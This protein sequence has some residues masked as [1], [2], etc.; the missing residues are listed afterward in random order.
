MRIGLIIYGSL[1]TRTG[2]YI[3]DK[4]LVAHLRRLG[5]ETEVISLSG[6]HYGRHLFDNVIPSVYARIIHSSVDLLLQDGLCHPSLFI[7]NNKLKRTSTLPIVSI[8]HQVLSSQ[9]RNSWPNAIYRAV[10]RR[11]L[12]SVDAFICNSQTTLNAV[13]KLTARKKPSLV[14]Y[15]AGDRLGF[16][17]PKEK[18]KTRALTK[19]PLKLLFI[20]NVLPNKG[21]HPL[22]QGLSHL[23]KDIW[24]LTV[25]GSLS[26]DT[27]YVRQIESLIHSRLSD[28]VNLT[29]SIDGTELARHLSHHQVL[30]MPFSH[31]GFGI[32]IIE[33]MA[34]GLPAIGSA[35]G[36]AKEI[37]VHGQNGFLIS[38]G[39]NRSLLQ[40]IQQLYHDRGRLVEMSSAALET[41]K[42]HP[43]WQDAMNAIHSFL[44]ECQ[45]REFLGSVAA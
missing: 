6:R 18:I 16:L 45:S 34:F 44:C 37:I 24:R 7:V 17:E 14:A 33:G 10:E 27:V 11:Y 13:E 20:G 41:F 32:A 19:G 28:Q 25:V 2:G 26:M 43:T 39:D 3:Y 22:I 4:I 15:P 5:H 12:A 35:S 42:S 9:P 31:E 38:P 30:V 21:L 23:P 8:M 40:Y 29:G 1:D 36:A